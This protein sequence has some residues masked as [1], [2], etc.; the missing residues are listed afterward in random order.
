M[1]LAI[2]VL[3]LRTVHLPWLVQSAVFLFWPV[4]VYCSLVISLTSMLRVYLTLPLS[5]PA[6]RRSVV[7]AVFVVG[8]SIWQTWILS[9]LSLWVPHR[10]RSRPPRKPDRLRRRQLWVSQWPAPSR[11]SGAWTRRCSASH[12][13]SMWTRCNS[14]HTRV[15]TSPT[16]PC[17]HLHRHL[18]LRQRPCPRHGEPMRFWMSQVIGEQ[19][20]TAKQVAVLLWYRGLGKNVRC[21]HHQRM[22]YWMRKCWQIHWYKLYFWQYWWVENLSFFS[23]IYMSCLHSKI[24]IFLYVCVFSFWTFILIYM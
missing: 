11:R 9:R 17:Q 5:C 20:W 22:Y 14:N 18:P 1:T 4:C 10:C 24:T 2:S 7:A 3:F 19:E 15:W 23:C 12:R 8:V 13:A 6:R 16:A 21:R